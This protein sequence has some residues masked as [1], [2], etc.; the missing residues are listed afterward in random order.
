MS[1]SAHRSAP[2]LRRRSE[3]SSAETWNLESVFATNADWE[4]AREQMLSRIPELDAYRGRTG[5]SAAVLLEVLNLR[6]ELRKR[7]DQVDVYAYLRRAEDATNQESAAL[8]E[9]ANNL[10]AAFSSAASFIQPEILA[11]PHETIEAYIEEEPGL[12]LYRHFFNKLARMR[13]HVR[14]AEI[15]ELLA[16]ADNVMYGFAGVR[17]ALEN[18]DL[19]L[20]KITDENGQEVQ[21]GQGNVQHYLHS[22]DRDLRRRAWISS[23]DAYLSKKNTFAGTLSGGIKRDVFNMRARN[24]SSS[25][26][27][28]LYPNAIPTEVFHNLVDTVWKNL[29]TWHRYFEI[30]K[31]VL[32]LDVQHEW[33]IAAPLSDDAP[34]ISFDEGM[35]IILESLA[36]LGEEYVGIVRQGVADRWVDAWPNIGKGGGAFSAGTNGTLPFISMSYQN[37][38]GSVSTLTHEL[39]HSMHSYYTWQNQPSTYSHY[40][41][42]VAEAASNMH[43][44]LLG[45]HLFG[46]ER[47][48]AFQI[49]MIEERMGNHLRY[50]FTM[51]ILAKFELDCHEKV[52]RGEALTADSMTATLAGIYN[53]AYG[54]HVEVD[55]DRMGITWARFPHLFANFYVFQYATGISAAAAMGQ[56]VISEG[57]PARQRYLEFLKAGD[58]KFPIDALRDAGIDM[59]DPAPVQAAFDILAG[60][61][62]RLDEL[63]R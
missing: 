14:S 61:V 57:E 16:Q 44:T 26:D 9:R 50:F 47:D 7:V 3:L 11:L 27:A 18:A 39:G 60:Y 40:S 48:T 36:P 59:R 56:Q 34:E 33:D 19:D 10:D 63:T 41:M 53:E 31:R 29:P 62:D 1:D 54:G 37:D 4:S 23:A 2:A 45:Q 5:S 6:D 24:F 55:H 8:A 28:A 22:T 25:L 38:L 32:G 12:E 43:Q 42:F 35:Q 52:E 21:L 58:S 51:P 49:A 20:G 13:D 15:E 46:Q 30:R 17:G